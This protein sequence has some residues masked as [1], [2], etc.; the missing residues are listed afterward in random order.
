MAKEK[1]AESLDAVHT[2]T[3][4]HTLY[5]YRIVGQSGEREPLLENKETSLSNSLTYLYY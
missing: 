2:H 1:T 3:H 4:T 5:F